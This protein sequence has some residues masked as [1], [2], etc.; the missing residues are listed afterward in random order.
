VASA[1]AHRRPR[2]PAFLG[3][4]RGRLAPIWFVLP[5]LIFLG[6]TSLYP[7]LVMLRMSVSDV[8]SAT[9]LREWPFVGLQNFQ[10][11]AANPDF[12]LALTNT[13][14]FMVIVVVFGV[15][16][17]F[18]TAVALKRDTRINRGLLAILVLA[19]ALPPVVSGSLWKFMLSHAGFVNEFLLSIGVIDTPVGWLITNPLPLI[20]VALITTWAAMPFA[21]VIFR[22]ALK[23]VPVDLLEAAQIDGAT[24]RQ[25][26]QSITFPLLLPTTVVLIVLYLVYAF[27]SFEFIFAVTGGG[28][29]T[30]T[31]TLPFL[32]YRQAFRFF[33][34]GIAAAIAALTMLLIAGVVIVYVRAVRAQAESGL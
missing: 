33:E 22:A 2:L 6:L 30:A 5:A 4:E 34:F 14:V 21:A 16:G 13:L 20:S 15:G 10:E 23:D 9:L 26:L 12:Q 32:G 1:N 29:G 7:L 17:G 3:L 25:Q 8:T 24:P 27:R 28:P 31:T 19:W 11:M 18:A